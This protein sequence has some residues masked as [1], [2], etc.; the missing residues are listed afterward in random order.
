MSHF[1][2]FG[3]FIWKQ[4]CPAFLEKELLNTLNLPFR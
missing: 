3:D 4:L 2:T 1:L